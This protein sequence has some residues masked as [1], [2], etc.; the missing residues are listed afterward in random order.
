[1]PSV[2]FIEADGTEHVV[3]LNVGTSLMQGAVTNLVP[4]IE[5]DCGGLCACATCH[6]YVSDVWWADCG[7][8]D[9]LEK[10]ILEFAYN[11][12][13]RSRLACQID[14]KEELS[15]MILQLPKRQY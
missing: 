11:A 8:P 15:E 10:N 1:M 2:T 4:G 5:G 14:M 7:E 6:I 12:D 9:E 3:E 13:R